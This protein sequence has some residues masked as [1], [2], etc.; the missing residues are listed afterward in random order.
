VDNADI[1][2]TKIQQHLYLLLG[3]KGSLNNRI[4]DAIHLSGQKSQYRKVPVTQFMIW[5]EHLSKR[6]VE[7]PFDL[8]T[9]NNHTEERPFHALHHLIRST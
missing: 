3:F 7:A 2:K 6:Y 1:I 5:S 9:S 4:R 8:I